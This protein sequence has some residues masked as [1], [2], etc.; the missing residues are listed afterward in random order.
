MAIYSNSRLELRH[1]LAHLMHDQTIGVV[2]SPGSGTFVCATTH[3]DKPDDHFNDYVEVFDYSGTGIGTSGNPTD[4]V[5]STHTLTFSPV[6]TLTAGD[7]VEIHQR[8]TVEEY[9]NAINHAI[10]LVANEALMDRVDESISLVTNTY[11]YNIPTQFLYI[12]ELHVSDSSG[13]YIDRLPLNNKTEWRPVKKTTAVIEFIKGNYAPVTGR[14]LRITGS[15]SPGRLET[16]AESCP[17]DPEYV[18]QA[19]KAYLHQSR[20]RSN[21]KDPEDHQGQ[22]QLAR[23]LAEARVSYMSANRTGVAIVEI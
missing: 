9:N 10:D 5:Q 13:N 18:I 19:A 1:L 2:A 20:I 15:A 22:M 21:A 23:V 4:W 8:F 6:A 11:Q 17:V 3:W 14:T 16:D 7:L 12:D